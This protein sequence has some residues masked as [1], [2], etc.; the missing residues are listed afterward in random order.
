LAKIRIEL[1]KILGQLA[2]FNSIQV[3]GFALGALVNKLT[4][5][6]VVNPDVGKALREIIALC[7]RAIHGE[8]ISEEGARAIV[9][10]GVELLE[11]LYWIAR[12]QAS[13][14][15]IVKEEIITSQ[16][17][18]EYYH[19]KRYRLTSIIPYVESPR[20]VVRELTQEQLD[21]VLE[22]YSD[23]AEFIVE[24]VEIKNG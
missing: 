23:Y 11:E 14:G 3:T 13:S 6:E 19:K 22:Y 9:D 18:D 20:R 4:N 2:R 15:T 21:E 5:Q 16:E 12:N 24:L 7:N 8:T 17:S 1:E 10:V